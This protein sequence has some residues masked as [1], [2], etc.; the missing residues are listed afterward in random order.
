MFHILVRVIFDQA[1]K[2]ICK[3]TSLRVM[4][5]QKSLFYP[6]CVNWNQR[7]VFPCL[8]LTASLNWTPLFWLAVVIYLFICTLLNWECSYDWESG[9]NSVPL[10]KYSIILKKF[11]NY[12]SFYSVNL[13]KCK[14]SLPSGSWQKSEKKKNLEYWKWVET[15][16]FHILFKGN[17]W[18]YSS[19]HDHGT[20]CMLLHMQFQF[21]C[22]R[23][24]D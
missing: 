5:V 10:P 14:I 16:E 17:L 2:V 6:L 3:S 15:I 8:R 20:F 11:G 7:H 18:F 9:C 13:T 22:L 19:P 21:Y 12:L 4:M 24:F 23:Q 1:P